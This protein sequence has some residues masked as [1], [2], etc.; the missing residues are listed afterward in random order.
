[1]YNSLCCL[2]VRLVADSVDQQSSES[3]GG[4][5]R[6]NSNV[7]LLEAEPRDRE[8]NLVHLRREGGVGVELSIEGVI[9]NVAALL[10]G[11]EGNGALFGNTDGGA[12]GV[13]SA[14]EVEALEVE[15]LDSISSDGDTTS[16][17]VVGD[18]GSG[19]LVA[20]LGGS[21]ADAENTGLEDVEGVVLQALVAANRVDLRDSRNTSEVVEGSDLLGTAVDEGGGRQREEGDKSEA[22]EHLDGFRV[23]VGVGVAMVDGCKE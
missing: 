3:L 11:S 23:V 17:E 9:G 2:V 21:A 5:G 20:R 4:G 7:N 10:I 22:G 13:D 8:F 18:G 16:G 19:D 15:V 6:D 14:E 12:N 1:M